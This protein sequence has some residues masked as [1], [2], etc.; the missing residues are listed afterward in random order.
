MSQILR[1][2]GPE[3]KGREADRKIHTGS[4]NAKAELLMLTDVLRVKS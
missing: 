4:E 2:G 3:M 1:I